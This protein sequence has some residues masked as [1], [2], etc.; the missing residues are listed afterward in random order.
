MSRIRRIAKTIAGRCVSFLVVM[1]L[2]SG[3]ITAQGQ[4]SQRLDGTLVV[5]VPASEGLVVC[6][7][8]RLYNHDA[9]SFT[10]TFVKIRKINSNALFVATHT[11]GFF[12]TQTGTMAFDAVEI[13][14]KYAA[15]NDLGS[16][17]PFWD[18]LKRE[19][20]AQLRAYLAGRRF[21]QWPESDKENSNLLFNLL[22]YSVSG[23][24]ARSHSVKVYYEKARIPVI[25]VTDPITEE[26]RTPKLGGKG[27]A[28]LNYLVRNPAA[29]NDPII[30]R[31]DE[32][33]FTVQGT[34]AVNAVS[35]ANRLFAIT[36]TGLPQARV[37]STFDCALLGYETG[38]RWLTGA[39]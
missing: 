22:F 37:S 35:F 5:A 31:F 11:I 6:S 21:A 26:V 39:H 20:N 12:D 2:T 14:A 33:N 3:L 18:G 24:R 10:D 13:T 25:L 8:K 19:I 15:K 4:A 32:S 7:D 23:N 30:A 34:S 38:F 28:L 1:L 16:G 17:K 27:K 36:S 29:A 9:R